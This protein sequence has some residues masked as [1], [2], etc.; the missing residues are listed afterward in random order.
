MSGKTRETAD[1][2]CRLIKKVP[3]ECREEF[4]ASLLDT[5][6][7]RM[8]IFSVYVICVQV[9][10][11][12][13]NMVKPSDSKSS[14]IM[15][16]VILSLG[17]LAVGI[18][19]CVLY[20]LARKGVIKSY[21][22]RQFLVHSFLYFYTVVQLTFCTLN[23]I[24]TGG[25]NSY[26]IAILIIGLFPV[27]RPAQSVTTILVAFVYL[28]AALYMTRMLSDTWDSILISDVWTNLIIITGLVICVSIIIYN[29]YVLNFLKS[30]ELQKANDGLEETVSV[31]TA[32]LKE[33]TE[34]AQIASRAKSEFL[35]RMSHEIRTPLNAI[36]GMAR[37]ARKSRDEEETVQALDEI[38]TASRHLLGILNDVLDMAR[39]ESGKFEL[40]EEAFSLSEALREVAGMIRPR[41]VEKEI[42]FITNH[43]QLPVLGVLGDRLHLKQ[44]FINLLG[45]AVKFTPEKG[46]I[47]F[48]AAMTGED[49]E[50]VAVTFM[51]R[52][53]GI[54]MDR[55]QMGKLFQAFE[56]GDASVTVNYG[57][58]GLGL[59]ISQGIIG[60]MG[61]KIELESEKG[62]G[63]QFYFSLRFKKAELRE[64]G[65]SAAGQQIP[66]YHGKRLLLVEDVAINRLIIQKLLKETGVEIAEAVNGQIACE[67]IAAADEHYYDLVLMD[68]QMPV[69]DGY[70]ATQKIRGMGRQ[71]VKTLPIIALSA[72]AYKEDMEKSRALG[73]DDHLSK[74]I[75]MAEVFAVLNRYLNIQ[76]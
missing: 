2:S 5:N 32:E 15:I 55:Q 37:I 75:E 10:L 69:M 13:I 60:Q 17:T 35:A 49:A 30:R 66:E 48:E 12:V 8:Y 45:N 68:I 71:D 65:P 29:M 41:C 23:I 57:G 4:A 24:S 63:S 33:Q 9:V 3:Q 56:Q 46:T 20:A 18:V 67:M 21:A 1:S 34:A 74:P 53:S 70:E 28:W 73:M 40:V 51:V 43:D 6:I 58:S 62:R 39:I 14:D 26:I 31:R 42:D 61:G 50:Y 59:S 22:A 54:G 47:S 52:D 44:V 76:F 25:I 38:D 36:I 19:Y 16:Y 11:N 27:I 7:Q 64:A 72:N